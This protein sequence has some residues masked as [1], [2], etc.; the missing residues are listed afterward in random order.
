MNAQNQIV[1]YQNKVA[2]RAKMAQVQHKELER[3]ATT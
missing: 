1:I 3:K 2:T